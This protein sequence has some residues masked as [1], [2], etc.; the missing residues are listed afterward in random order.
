MKKK[1]KM[2][3]GKLKAA[4]E[5]LKEVGGE[6]NEATL[7]EQWEDQKETTKAEGKESKERRAVYKKLIN[8][9]KARDQVVS[10]MLVPSLMTAVNGNSW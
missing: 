2:T 7:V 1:Y 6:F 4:E 8:L 3:N 5:K 9:V 10:K